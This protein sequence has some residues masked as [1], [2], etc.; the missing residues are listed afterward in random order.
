VTD[1]QHL[2]P[3]VQDGRDAEARRFVHAL[4]LR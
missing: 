3:A 4:S 2:G 1:E